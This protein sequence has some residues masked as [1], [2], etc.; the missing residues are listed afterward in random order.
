VNAGTPGY[1]RAATFWYPY[2][3]ATVN[4]ASVETSADQSGAILIPIPDKSADVSLYFQEPNYLAAARYVSLAVWLGI[5]LVLIG[6]RDK[7]R[8]CFILRN[9]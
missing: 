2:W 9:S 3:K 4:G 5:A 8:S 7:F 6:F 1:V